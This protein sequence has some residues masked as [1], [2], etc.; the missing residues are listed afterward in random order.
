MGH[1]LMEGVLVSGASLPHG[2]YCQ[3][4]KGV[5]SEIGLI[6][7]KQ[8]ARAG[9]GYSTGLETVP[10]TLSSSQHHIQPPTKCL[11]P[12]FFLCFCILTFLE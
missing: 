5:S 11:S 1:V 8:V 2:N 9:G 10:F 6:P 12:Q 7:I 3:R 4:S